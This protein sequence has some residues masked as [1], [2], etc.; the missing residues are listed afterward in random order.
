M[1]MS[2]Q[3]IITLLI[4][5]AWMAAVGAAVYF[6]ITLRASVKD[7]ADALKYAEDAETN[8]QFFPGRRGG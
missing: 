5:F 1:P 4:F 2:E 8:R 6:A 3:M 7:I